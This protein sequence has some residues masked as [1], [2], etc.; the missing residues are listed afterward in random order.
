MQA[1]YHD[2][3]RKTG[4]SAIALISILV[5]F[6]LVFLTPFSS[7]QVASS[8]P[9]KVVEGIE[10]AL[11]ARDVDAVMVL[12]AD[13]A[14]FRIVPSTLLQS[15]GIFTGKDEIRRWVQG[16]ADDNIRVEVESRRVEGEKI[17]TSVEVYLDSF[18][19]LGI[20]PLVGSAEYFVQDSKLK[21][22]TFTFSQESLS[23]QQKALAVLQPVAAL[24]DALNSHD[25]DSVLVLF[26]D[27]AVFVDPQGI[28]I[29][30]EKIQA[31][32]EFLTTQNVEVEMVGSPRVEVDQV[33]MLLD[34]S[35]DVYR[36]LGIAPLR[37]ILEAVVQDSKIKSLTFTYTPESAARLQTAPIESQL[38][39]LDDEIQELRSDVKVSKEATAHIRAEIETIQGEL[40]ILKIEF[41]E[42]KIDIQSLLTN[43]QVQPQESSTTTA[44]ADFEDQLTIAALTMAVIAITISSVVAVRSR[45]S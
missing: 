10:S 11:N 28:F 9:E 22:V 13:D 18:L 19:A 32:L 23:K 45:R 41:D 35:L 6:S 7:A 36:E 37:Q 3:R 16:V 40:A 17:T 42:L 26:R 31:N 12:V 33:I 44:T 39:A 29:G 27:D 25:I 38:I 2:T 43:L 14:V 8:D 24:R 34:I 15:T 5:F 20:Y 30:K 4:R 21:S 1:L